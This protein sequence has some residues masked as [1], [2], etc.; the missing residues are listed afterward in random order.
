[1][2]PDE[3]RWA[4]QRK[5]GNVLRI[6]EEIYEM[7]TLAVIETIWQDLRYGARLL[8]R[9][10]A[11]TAV[12][13]LS[14]MLGIGANTAIFQLIDAV[15]LQSL[16]VAEPSQLV[17]VRP[18]GT[19]PRPGNVITR[20]AQ[21]TNPQWERLRA[22]QQAFS[23]I[24][25]WAPMRLN[26]AAGGEIRQ[27]QAIFVSGSFFEMLGVS[28]SRG[29]LLA[30]ADDQRGCSSHASVI[31]D[32][33]WQR[34][35][36]GDPAILGRSI[37]LENQ[38]F[39]I[40]G[41]TPPGFYG[42]EVGRTFDVAV[43]I[44]AAAALGGDSG[45]LDDNFTWWLST[46]GRLRPGWSVERA[47]VHLQTISPALF[48]ETAS[49]RLDPEQIEAYRKY[50]LEAVPRGG[51]FS[52]LRTQYE[53]PLWLLLGLSA[54]VLLVACANLANLLLARA[55]ARTREMAVRLATGA[56]RGR[57]IRQLLSESLLLA[58]IG[59][60]LGAI[61]ARVISAGLVSFLSTGR[62]PL[63]VPIALDWRVLGFTA[64]TAIATTVLFGLAP[65]LRATSAP[66]ESVMR[67]SSR[68]LTA[69]RGRFGWQRALV[70]AQVALSLVMVLVALLFTLSLRNLTGVDTGFSFDN[71]AVADI[72]FGGLAVP[73]DRRLRL[74]RELLDGVRSIPGVASA[75]QVSFV[76]FGGWSARDE[77]RLE[78]RPQNP[79]PA[80]M[81]DVSA[82]YFET[83]RTPLAAGRDF[84][85]RD[86]SG[87]PAVVIVNQTF[88]RRYLAGTPAV[89]QRIQMRTGP[90]QW[91]TA[92]IVGL[93]N[94]TTY[95]DLREPFQPI[96]YRAAAQE[97]DPGMDLRVVLRSALSLAG[98]RSAV[99]KMAASH[100]PRITLS[101]R[102]FPSMVRE[103]LLRDWL[104]AT[105]SGFFGVLALLLASI[106]LYGVMAYM[107]A[108]RRSEIGIRLALGASRRSIIR[109]V[110]REAIVLVGVGLALGALLAVVASRAANAMLFGVTPT[111]PIAIAAA[112]GLLAT[113]GLI[114]SYLP[115]RRAAGLQP[116]HALPED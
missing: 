88:A 61:L 26:L 90:Q 38:A 18:S 46:L 107:V 30:T 113:V 68:G 85:D 5:L 37:R 71:L 53:A 106:G 67:M 112:V 32:A 54:L 31:S 35:Y 96:V 56:S 91:S 47:T 60:V 78:G 97:R 70:V 89:G 48:R 102:A 64:A 24:L 22:D 77:V 8:R 63:S 105:L 28:A 72:D 6:R 83:M 34:E 84:D 101:F 75:A 17:E 69:N 76:P 27:A 44:C 57:V 52:S 58:A 92:E 1:M 33:F 55:G 66:L 86:T 41:V 59:T 36:G 99:A 73:A 7:N 115:A 109:M 10:P 45:V 62:D 9:H 13:L 23:S 93:V 80:S 40:V 103:T 108:R 65:A 29:R 2:A 3:A 116:T 74:Q 11:F 114:A 79:L 4:A 43:P 87:S 16:P 98:V 82:W 100:D 20:Y 111:D 94:D 51:G 21:L 42:V 49:E 14:L 81:N 39:D 12:A 95:A 19:Q 104:M 15:R 110:M 50:R 25:A